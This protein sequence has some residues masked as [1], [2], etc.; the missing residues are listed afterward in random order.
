MGKTWT[1]SDLGG[2]GLQSANLK[3][4]ALLKKHRT[5]YA[6]L[7]LFPLGAHRGYLRDRRGAWLYRAVSLLCLA[8]YLLGESAV[9][10]ALFAALAGGAV[11]DLFHVDRWVTRL[12]K[13]LRMQVYLGQTAGA[14]PGFEG[15]HR[16]K[17][18]KIQ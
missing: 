11:Y 14:P 15:H 12:N 2:G 3:L 4:A 6:L 17:T 16:D 1:K 13:Q 10:L 8:A 9:S 7:A 5:A 18:D